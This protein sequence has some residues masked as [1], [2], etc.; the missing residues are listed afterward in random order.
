MIGFERRG[1]CTRNYATACRQG[2]VGKTTPRQRDQRTRPKRRDDALAGLGGWP[3][4]LSI[5]SAIRER[6]EGAGG[7]SAPPTCR[8]DT[9][10]SGSEREPAP[11]AKRV[12]QM[13]WRSTSCL[14]ITWRRISFVPSP[15]HI[16]IASP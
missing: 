1:E 11:A 9:G 13:R 5:N 3:R 12:S 4:K 8:K 16:S 14:A 2:S 15:M 10:A 7:G 6:R